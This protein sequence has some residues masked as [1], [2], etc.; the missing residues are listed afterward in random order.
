MHH[1]M[2]V[3]GM[4][5]KDTSEKWSR[6]YACECEAGG[7]R[8]HIWCHA[9]KSWIPSQHSLVSREDTSDTDRTIYTGFISHPNALP[10]GYP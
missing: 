4:G 10:L 6:V 1:T 8:M 3:A 2:L 9:E 7:T 5:Q